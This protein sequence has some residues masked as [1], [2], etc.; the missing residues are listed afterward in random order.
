LQY[1]SV[2]I[3]TVDPNTKQI[4]YC[5]QNLISGHDMDMRILIARKR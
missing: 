5:V 2:I 3:T 1:A 4:I